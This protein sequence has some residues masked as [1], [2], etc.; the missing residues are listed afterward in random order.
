MSDGVPCVFVGGPIDGELRTL[1]PKL[2]QNRVVEIPV[3]DAP[4]VVSNVL[5]KPVEALGVDVHRYLRTE[6]AEGASYVVF[7][8]DTLAGW[9]VMDMLIQKYVAVRR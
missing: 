9:H 1:E 2:A 4:P 8:H 7:R 5:G 6:Q 3:F